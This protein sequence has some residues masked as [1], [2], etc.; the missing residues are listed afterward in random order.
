MAAHGIASHP[1][2]TY[3]EVLSL[4]A[5]SELHGA[6]YL[7]QQIPGVRADSHTVKYELRGDIEGYRDKVYGRMWVGSVSPEDLVGEHDAWDIRE[8]Y[9]YLWFTYSTLLRPLDINPRVVQQIINSKPD[10]IINSIPRSVLCVNP[11]HSFGETSIVAAGD[12]PLMGIRVPFTCPNFKVICNG[13]DNPSWYRLSRVFDHTTVEWPASVGRVP[14][15]S[16][17]TVRKPTSTDCDCWPEIKHVG[18]YGKWEKGV[19]SHTAY[20]DARNYVEEKVNGS[21][22][23]DAIANLP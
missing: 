8:T 17:S 14:V 5:K 19:L 21:S 11:T 16:A 4:G 12:A 1:D 23:Q 7:H 10:L 18:R 6:Q 2:I 15:S 9:D 20:E 3:L 22:G 13:D